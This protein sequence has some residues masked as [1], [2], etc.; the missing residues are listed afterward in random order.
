MRTEC[1][2]SR[3]V[4]DMPLPVSRLVAAIGDSI[5]LLFMRIVYG[6]CVFVGVLIQLL[7]FLHSTISYK[8]GLA[9]LVK[10]LEHIFSS[11]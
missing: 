6:E 2:N 11:L 7:S 3:Y 5:L 4:F 9:K 10:N 8:K 1:L